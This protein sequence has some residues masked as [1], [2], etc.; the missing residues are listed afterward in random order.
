MDD[1]PDISETPGSEGSSKKNRK[2]PRKSAKSEVVNVMKD[3]IEQQEKRQ[4]EEG[5]TRERMHAEKL[6]IMK[7]LIQA[8]T[9]K[10]PK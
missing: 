7:Q 1:L 9:Q 4:E 6:D 2:R 8:M 3:Y 5:H 10:E